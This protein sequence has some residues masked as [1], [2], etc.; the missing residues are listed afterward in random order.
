MIYVTL[1]LN[2]RHEGRG[3]SGQHMAA[4]AGRGGRGGHGKALEHRGHACCM[5]L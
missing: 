1:Y 4:V 5:Y 2:A 3:V